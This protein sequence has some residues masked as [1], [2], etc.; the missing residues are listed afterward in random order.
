MTGL[1]ERVAALDDDLDTTRRASP[2]WRECEEWLRSVP[3]MGP[4]WARTRGLEL[5]A[6]G[7]RS[8][9]RLAA[10][11]GVAPWKRDRGTRRGRRTIWGGRAHVRATLYMSPLVAVR[12]NPVRKACYERLRTAGKAAKGALTA[13]M[14]KLLTMLNAMVTHHTPGQAQKVAIA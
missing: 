5:P 11:V 3:G 14:R 4:A 6:L 9:Q 8:R 1:H 7:T 13:C 12:S 10:W 2:V